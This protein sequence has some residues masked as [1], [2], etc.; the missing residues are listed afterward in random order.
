MSVRPK[1][2]IRA[3]AYARYS[4][5]NQRAASIED[6]LRNCQRRADAEGW[7][8]VATFA[9][10][11]ISG[12]DA[13]RPEYQAMLAAAGRGEFDVLLVDDL[14]RLA[15]DSVEQEKAIR[16]LEFQQV[17][18]VSPSDG[19]DSTS[20]ARKVHRGFKG[21]MNEIFLDDLAEKV[22]RGQE[23]QARK[24]FWNGGKPYGFRLRPILDP[25][26]T[27]PYGQPLKIGTKLEV[28]PE[29]AAV[30]REIFSSFIAGKSYRTIAKELNA[31]GIPSGGAAWKRRVRRC[32]GWTGSAVRVI[33]TNPLYTGLVRW[34]TSQFVRDP[35]TGKHKRRPRPK[36]EWNEY[37]DESLRIVADE[38]FR[39]AQE[40]PRMRGLAQ[41]RSGGRA[42]Y[43]L[44]G[45]LYCDCGAHFVMANERGYS[46][47]GHREGA[48]ENKTWV[49]REA[50]EAAVLEPLRKELL[51]PDRVAR[52]AREMQRAY[53]E[54]VT[55]LQKQA[56]VAPKEIQ[57]IDDRVQRLRERQ[58]RGD[59]DMTA[60][61]LQVVID[62]LL[63]ERK[64]LEDAQPAAKAGAQ[65]LALLP[66]AAELYRRQ[67]AIGLDGDARA[68]QK[69]RLA[70]RKLCGPI[71]LRTEP[72]NSVW[73]CFEMQPAALVQGAVGTGYRGER[74]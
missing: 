63:G 44:S 72:D 16:R 59:P 46:C 38:T 17:R 66:K 1:P 34:N 40:R 51:A 8:I 24:G 56:T 39:A 61:E 54:H 42:R 41:V 9:D 68:V 31:R 55:K 52:M 73:A 4:S 14:S 12:S 11:A 30:V 49:R 37:R 18:V 69:A 27:D 29:Q 10:A 5:D 45:I 22:H 62:R 65:F 2:L 53:V 43:L 36:H 33:L 67:I 32:A 48:C 26:Q 3:A 58:R 13:N 64:K 35:D 71:K 70:L 60:D 50:V 19:Y 25:N 74:I 57:A 6:Q 23:G 7:T 47:Q 20:K 15:R 28:N 21:L